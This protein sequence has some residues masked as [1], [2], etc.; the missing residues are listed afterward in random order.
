MYF[1][2]SIMSQKKKDRSVASFQEDW[3]AKEEFKSWLRKVLKRHCI[4]R[5]IG[6]TASSE[7]KNAQS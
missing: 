2:L 3:L 7:R 5:I 6:P 4:W 1:R